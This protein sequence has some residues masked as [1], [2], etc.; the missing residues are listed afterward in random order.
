MSSKTHDIGA[1]A[2]RIEAFHAVIERVHEEHKAETLIQI[3]HQPGY[4]TPAEWAMLAHALESAINQAEAAAKSYA[5][6]VGDAQMVAV[7][8]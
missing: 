1:L 5:A 6:L 3:I 8:A 2:K 4:T 7:K